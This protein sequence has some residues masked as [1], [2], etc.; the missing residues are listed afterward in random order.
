MRAV[1]TS[2]ILGSA[3]MFAWVP[4]GRRK[5]SFRSHPSWDYVGID[6]PE[7]DCVIFMYHTLDLTFFAK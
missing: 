7:E 5:E 1:E 3:E 4:T 2:K 6:P